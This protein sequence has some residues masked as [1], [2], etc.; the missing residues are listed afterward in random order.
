MLTATVFERCTKAGVRKLIAR[1]H[2]E[3]AVLAG[4]QLAPASGGFIPPG[5]APEAVRRLQ[6]ADFTVEAF[7]SRGLCES[8][9]ALHR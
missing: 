5:S 3:L 6:P 9:R 7:Q 1:L 2:E 8:K 4:K